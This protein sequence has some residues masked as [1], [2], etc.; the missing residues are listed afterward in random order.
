RYGFPESIISDRGKEFDSQ[1]MREVCRLLGI[2][3]RYSTAY[4]PQTQGSV[5][6]FNRTMKNMLIKYC[7]RHKDDWDI[8]LQTLMF[9]YRSS[10]HES[11]GMSPFLMVI[12]RGGR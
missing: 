6:R 1:V 12:G 8:W 10:P 11:N 4:H 2:E 7:G 5:E 9:A 3:K